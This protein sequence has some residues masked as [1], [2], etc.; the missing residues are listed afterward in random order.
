MHIVYPRGA[1]TGI[2]SRESLGFKYTVTQFFVFRLIIFDKNDRNMKNML[3]GYLRQLK[4]R[5]VN[6][7]HVRWV[8][9]AT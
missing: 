1:T 5:F 7:K 2:K 3:D 4:Y 8:F 6:E 9:T